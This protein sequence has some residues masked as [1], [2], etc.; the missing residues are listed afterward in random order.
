MKEGTSLPRP[1]FRKCGS[2]NDIS[3]CASGYSSGQVRSCQ[4]PGCG[5][6]WIGWGTNLFS[7][8]GNTPPS[9]AT[10]P[11]SAEMRNRVRATCHPPRFPA[12]ADRQTCAENRRLE[13]LGEQHAQFLQVMRVA[14][15]SFV[16]GASPI[17]AVEY[18]RRSIPVESRPSLINWER[19]KE[20]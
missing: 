16:R 12:A 13:S 18:A 8:F 14:I 1:S 15:C 5:G 9:V 4:T 6:V 10:A 3:F 2:R 20:G 19:G 7:P 11:S 17:L